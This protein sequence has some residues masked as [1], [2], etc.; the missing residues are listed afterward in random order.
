MVLVLV[1]VR[2]KMRIPQRIQTQTLVFLFLFQ[3]FLKQLLLIFRDW[4]FSAAASHTS[5]LS[6]RSVISA[7]Y[8]KSLC[9]STLQIPSF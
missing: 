7:A 2:I 4:L 5:P 1:L 8:P 6:S 3:L 9:R